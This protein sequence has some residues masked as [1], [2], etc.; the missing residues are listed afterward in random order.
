MRQLAEVGE[1]A[2]RNGWSLDR[3]S[4]RQAR[5]RRG[6]R[7][8]VDPVRDEDRPRVRGARAWEEATGKV[9]RIALPEATQ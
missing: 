5:R 2:A 4:A 6:L 9:E 8:D 7:G 3:R 1:Q